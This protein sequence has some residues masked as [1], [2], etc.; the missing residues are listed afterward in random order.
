MKRLLRRATGLLSLLLLAA[1]VWA[2]GWWLAG[3]Q[4]APAAPATAAP[5]TTPSATA[6]QTPTWIPYPGADRT[7]SE[8]TRPPDTPRPTPTPSNTAT[9][10]T[11][12][13]EPSSTPTWTPGPF[14]TPAFKPTPPGTSTGPLQHLWY[15]YW[16]DSAATPQLRA[17]LVDGNGQ[18]WGQAPEGI[19]LGLPPGWP[20]WTQ[21][22]LCSLYPSP[23]SRSAIAEF[24]GGEFTD[25]PSWVDLAARAIRPLFTDEQLRPGVFLAWAPDSRRVLVG[26]G[27]IDAGI[28]DK[29]LVDLPTQS[30][31]TIDYSSVVAQGGYVVA[32]AFSPQGGE[33]ADASEYLYSVTRPT[34]D[35]EIGVRPA[36]PGTRA[37]LVRLAGDYD[38]VGG[39][40]L[41]WSPD[42]QQLAVVIGRRVADPL[43]GNEDLELWLVERATGSARLLAQ[44]LAYPPAL[45]SPDGRSVLFLK[46]ESPITRYPV[47]TNVYVFDLATGSER[48]L[49][50]FTGRAVGPV[51]WSPDGRQAAF[52]LH[53]GG[54]AE[55]WASDREGTQLVAVAGPAAPSGV[56]MWL[57]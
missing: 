13:P 54:Y 16:P 38:S 24:C 52:A 32:A 12:T 27:S 6:P 56:F 46:A 44:G 1:L 11:I 20:R 7:P 49:T 34:S 10:Y 22:R 26:P 45:W 50:H 9:A 35:V 23:D 25:P 31:E 36:G 8:P 55:I 5:T 19:D 30:Y 28:G 3:R 18:R 21:R 15:P 2:A 33:L 29:W 51:A 48:A 43:L 41:T 47:Y 42:G 17:E 14:F 37:V 40:G 57:P 4:P 39:H 53:F